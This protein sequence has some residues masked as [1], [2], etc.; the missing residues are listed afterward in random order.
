MGASIGTTALTVVL[1]NLLPISTVLADPKTS[2]NGLSDGALAGLVFGC[3]FAT[4]I[5]CAVSALALWY[6]KNKR[7]LRSKLS[8]ILLVN[9]ANTRMGHSCSPRLRPGPSIRLKNLT[10]SIATNSL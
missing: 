1:Y 7:D 6:V 8:F 3:I 10:T 4:I 5:V 9:I 2:C